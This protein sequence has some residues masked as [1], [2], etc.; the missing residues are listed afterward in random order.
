MLEH[1]MK[2]IDGRYINKY[3]ATTSE[4]LK[5]KVSECPLKVA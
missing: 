5:K 2:T 1:F 3:L 4:L